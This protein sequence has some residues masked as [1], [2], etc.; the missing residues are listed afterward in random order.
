[1]ITASHL[2]PLG[3][4]STGRRRPRAS[5]KKVHGSLAVTCATRPDPGGPAV[6][7]RSFFGFLACFCC[8]RPAGGS[9][10]PFSVSVQ[11]PTA[12]GFDQ[13]AVLTLNSS[14]TTRW[15]ARHCAHTT[16][17]LGTSYVDGL[18]CFKP[19]FCMDHFGT[20]V[21]VWYLCTVLTGRGPP[22]IFP[23]TSIKVQR[24]GFRKTG[25]D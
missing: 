15:T 23:A 17:I 6:F 12:S 24:L 16:G 25:H 13:S 18:R 21:N 19:R 22:K 9:I 14:P 11:A 8:S 1:M 2:A 3:G 4:Q 7:F 10:R 20:D 5:R